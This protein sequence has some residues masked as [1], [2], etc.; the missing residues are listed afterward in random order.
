MSRL[1]VLLVLLVPGLVHAQDGKKLL[2]VWD[3][4]YLAGARAGYIHTVTQEFK[5]D[6]VTVYRTLIE[7]R[8]TVKRNQDV[9]QLAMDSGSYE[10]PEGRV[11]AVFMKQYL[12]KNKTLE[13]VGKVF[14]DELKLTLD[15][16]DLKSAPWNA[17][18][19]GS[20][21][22]QVFLKEK[23]AKP[24]DAFKYLAYEP[25]VS[26]PLETTALV[27]DYEEV[28]LFNGAQKKKLLRVETKPERIGNVQLPTLTSWLDEDRMPLRSQVE[29]PGLGQVT[30]YRTTEQ[31]AKA[32][33]PIASLPDVSFNHLV[34]LNRKLP[35]PLSLGK[36]VYRLLLQ[37]DDDPAT[38]FANTP[39]QE[40]RNVRGKTFELHVRN[41]PAVKQS[42][43]KSLSEYME[44]N[45]F[46]TSD[47]ALV[48]EQ[49]K[50]AVGQEQDPLKKALR[51]EKWVFDRMKPSNFEAMATA[52]QVAK[53]LEGDCSEYAMLTAALCRAA[54]VPSRTAVGLIYAEVKGQPMLA[55]HMWTEVWANDAWRSLDATLGR[56][57]IGAGHLKVADQS[58]HDTR[59]L[60]PLLPVMRVVGR[61]SAEIVAV[62]GK[63]SSR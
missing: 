1:A 28:E 3:A 61:L 40:V 14:G 13:V 26:L 54:G 27:K 5:Q 48:R 23:E 44:S 58:W 55:F 41:E 50:M 62:E 16:K 18:V 12:G 35:D 57:G 21:R 51:I 45:Y 20:Y 29:V 25:S 11:G 2:D 30:L 60:T 38:A 42:E 15:G 46:V 8:I 43:P 24:G 33:G 32:P 4:A 19:L 7:L 9:V 56:G 59:S 63:S 49:A 39:S 47:N 52:D 6:G 31:Q 22:Q 36:V 34:R 10:Y 37:S 17:N 53:T